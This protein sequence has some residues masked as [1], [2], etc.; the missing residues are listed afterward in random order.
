METKTK[1]TYDMTLIQ[2]NLNHR[3]KCVVFFEI[4][5]GDTETTLTRSL[6]FNKAVF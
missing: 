2:F 5:Y 1:N 6:L 4:K 3:Y